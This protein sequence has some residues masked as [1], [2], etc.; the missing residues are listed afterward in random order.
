[1][2]RL[3]R[4]PLAEYLGAG[5]PVTLNTDSRLMD[6]ITLVDEYLA[7]HAKLGLDRNALVRIAR[8]GFAHAFVDDA[9]RGA[10]LA[11]FDAA[12]TALA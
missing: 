5:I 8:N 11:T 12:V 7:V 3:D 6:R 10:M 1:V 2:S 9:E 4:H